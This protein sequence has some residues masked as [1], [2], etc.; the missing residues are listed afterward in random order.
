MTS[1]NEYVLG[2][3]YIAALRYEPISHQ[4]I[5]QELNEI[6]RLNAQHLL[7]KEQLGYVIHPRIPIREN[8]TVA[9]IG[10]GTG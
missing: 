9:D 3:G 2:R 8:L 1:S 7:W 5:A 10:A 6:S 4:W